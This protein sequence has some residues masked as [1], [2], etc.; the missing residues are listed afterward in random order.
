MVAVQRHSMRGGDAP[1][2]QQ[3]L[4]RQRHAVQRTAAAALR[5]LGVGAAGVL[6]RLLRHHRHVAVQPR[7]H[8]LDARQH[9]AGHLFRRNAA[10]LD[11]APHLQQFEMVQF[12]VVHGMSPGARLRGA[13]V[14]A[15]EKPHGTH[16]RPMLGS[17]RRRRLFVRVSDLAQA[18][19]RLR[20]VQPNAL[21][22]AR[23]KC[24]ASENPCAKAAS[25]TLE[26]RPASGPGGWPAT[27][28]AIPGPWASG[29]AAQRPASRYGARRCAA[30]P[31]IAAT[32]RAS[33]GCPG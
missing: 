27:A 19:S 32:A 6:H 21:R 15:L 20:G 16:G 25:V 26:Q 13:T 7:V 2:P 11:L 4:E 1:G 28:A 10:G 24:A 17:R 9:V 5:D 29:C 18:A 14:V 22:K 33:P 12:A 30:A 31:A 8:G 23:L 3:V